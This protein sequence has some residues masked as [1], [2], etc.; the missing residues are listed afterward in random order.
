WSVVA[1]VPGKGYSA[2][3]TVAN[4][5]AIL[6]TLASS[7]LEFD[8]VPSIAN[9]AM[10]NT[11]I[12]G[13]FVTAFMAELTPDGESMRWFNVGHTPPVLATGDRTIRL[14]SLG[15]PLGVLPTL[16]V[17]PEE[18]PLDAGALLG[19]FTDGVTELRSKA[20]GAEMYGMERTEEWVG[21]SLGMNRGANRGR[22]AEE[23]LKV[24]T[25]FGAPARDDDLTMLFLQR[26]G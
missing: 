12:H 7:A 3:L 20:D 5:H 22:R 21:K 14:E 13:R 10:S 1:D 18:Q 8:K 9:S 16:S 25:E 23:F 15:P 2:A 26:D 11:L 17:L 19:V 6:H 24:L 4:L